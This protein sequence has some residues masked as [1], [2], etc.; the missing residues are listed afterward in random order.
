MLKIIIPFIFVNLLSSM[1]QEPTYLVL[2]HFDKDI[3]QAEKLLVENFNNSKFEFDA[4]LE[5]IFMDLDSYDNPAS[6]HMDMMK[7]LGEKYKVSFILLNKI[8]HK[9][10]RFVLDGL[11]FNTRSG[12]LIHRRKIDLKQYLD[13]Q[14]NELIMWV[15]N[16]LGVQEK[17]WQKNRESILFNDPEE[18]TYDKTP[19]GA[20]IRSLIAPGWGQA[21]SNKKTSAG[22]WFGVEASL[23]L[24]FILSY[25]N[26]DKSAKGFLSNTDLYHQTDD[27]KLVAKH[28]A[29]AE[30]DWGNHII[31]SR[32]AIA[33]ASAT[34]TGWV[35]NSIHAWV[36]GPRPYTNI[37]QEWDSS[38]ELNKG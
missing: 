34:S 38:S 7:E 35:S 10:D 37:Y 21:Y 25:L 22:V 33:L 29:A 28:R 3:P 18:L 23:S 9:E 20:A 27:E 36:F 1:N 32:L 16:T 4:A 6:S 19:M 15:G 8:E 2:N 26:Y 5:N 24:A 14:I 11:L 17:E 31:Y 30:K 12:G 13:G